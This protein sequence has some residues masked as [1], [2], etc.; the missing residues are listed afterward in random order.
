MWIYSGANWP[1]PNAATPGTTALPLS[2]ILTDYP[3]IRM[4]PLFPQ[5]GLR[6]GEP[7]P[8]GLTANL[9]NFSITIGGN[10][11]TYDFGN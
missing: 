7:G 9:D 5:I 4:H 10:T 8:A 2:Q 1:A 6:V 11:K 3:S